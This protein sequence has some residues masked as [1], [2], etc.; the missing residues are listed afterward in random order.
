MGKIPTKEFPLP[1]AFPSKENIPRYRTNLCGELSAPT[2]MYGGMHALRRIYVS[3]ACLVL[4]NMCVVH[5][6]IYWI[7]IRLS[8]Y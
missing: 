2:G 8:I 4:V 5:I 7:D 1:V 3:V 6:H